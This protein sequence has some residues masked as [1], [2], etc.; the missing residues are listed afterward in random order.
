MDPLERVHPD[1]DT[2][3]AL[4]RAAAM[5]GHR[6]FVCEGR[7]VWLSGAVPH[8]DVREVVV[9]PDGDRPTWKGERHDREVATFPMVWIRPD[10]PFDEAYL[11]LTWIL[12]RTD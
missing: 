8:A 7:E 11:E 6:T 5:R 1:T 12:E 10:P 3:W 4:L 2:T 9:P